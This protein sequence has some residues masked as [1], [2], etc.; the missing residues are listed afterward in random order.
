MSWWHYLLLVNFY[1]VLFFGFYAL[2]LRRETFFQLNRI[3]LV[4]ASLLSFFI[5]LIQSSWVKN[6]FITQQV[7][8]TIFNSPILNSS[9]MIYGSSYTLAQN[10]LT[11]G[12]IVN[13][14]YIAVTLFLILR[15][16]WQLVILKKAIEK[17]SPSAAYSFF[18]KIS[19]GNNL[20]NP[21]VI[22]AHEQVHAGQW[23]SVDV[24]IIETVMIINWFNPVVYLYRFAIKYIHEFIADRQVVKAGTDKADYALL[25]LSQTFNVPTH[26]LV[27][28]FYNHSLLKQRIKMLQKSKS[29]RIALAKYG[30]SAPLFIMM[31]VL[32]SA[33][34]NNSKAVKVID[35][36]AENVFLSST[37]DLAASIT[38]HA[39]IPASTVPETDPYIEMY[40]KSKELRIDTAQ[41][42][43]NEA[44]TSVES[45]PKFPGSLVDFLRSNIRYPTALRQANI[46]GKVIVQFIVETD[47]SIK[48][49]KAIEDPGYGS[50]EE[51][52]R[53]MTLSPK[54]APAYQN[55]K[56]IKVMYSVPINFTLGTSRNTAP[57]ANKVFAVAEKQPEF[58]GGAEK[59]NEFLT[60]NIRYPL[61]MRQANVQG[62]VIVQFIV[63]EDGSLSNIEVLKDQGFGSGEEAVRVLVLSPKWAPG[64]QNGKTV[65]V[66][67][68]V[69][70]NFTLEKLNPQVQETIVDTGSHKFAGTVTSPKGVISGSVVLADIKDLTTVKDAMK[71]RGLNNPLFFVDDVKKDRSAF[72]NIDITKIENILIVNKGQL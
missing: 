41:F 22:A 23:H 72:D 57:D 68:T 61:A 53:V 30:L 65:R 58:P 55:G 11:L 59:F 40:N 24:M 8:H 66:A 28:P 51:A 29:H 4:T 37:D 1:L 17:P 38:D 69:P 3:Y 71:N 46:Q 42:S 31:M 63:E 50:G 34:I 19:L 67:Y 36:K 15:L 64:Y 45:A 60:R 49:I 25:L 6:L 47:G 48:G 32:S 56:P 18:K 39:E 35:Q 44:Y 43:A 10:S 27:N 9:V 12:E 62:K 5:P 7:Q 13:G 54:W 20:E 21:D 33:T 2:L 70:V 14:I 52:E 26:A 16:I